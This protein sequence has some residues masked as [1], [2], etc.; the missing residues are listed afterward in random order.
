[1]G[2]LRFRLDQVV[3][4]ASPPT[5]PSVAKALTRSAWLRVPVF[6][7]SERSCDRTVATAQERCAAIFSTERLAAIATATPASAS[8]RSKANSTVKGSSSS[9]RANRAEASTLEQERRIH[10]AFEPDELPAGTLSSAC[11]PID[12]RA[13][14]ACAMFCRPIAARGQTIDRRLQCP[15]WLMAC[16]D[17]SPRTL[18]QDLRSPQHS[19]GGG[20]RMVDGSSFVHDQNRRGDI[21]QQRVA[22]P[23][24]F[25]HGLDLTIDRQRF[26]QMN[27]QQTA[28][29]MFLRGQWPRTEGT[30]YADQHEFPV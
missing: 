1:M 30:I 13:V 7:N 22:D 28:R 25:G 5:C 14:C 19:L 11:R 24:E 16:A 3:A 17:Q 23:G 29:F 18:C 10:R 6:A 21:A 27:R 9:E 12:A 20:I 8:V 15:L 2:F 26:D 4:V